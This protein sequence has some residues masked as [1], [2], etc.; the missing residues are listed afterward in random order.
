M[1]SAFGYDITSNLAK[2]SNGG[3]IDEESPKTEVKSQ[4][5]KGSKYSYEI[6][7]ENFLLLEPEL[8]RIFKG[9]IDSENHR[10]FFQGTSKERNQI[11]IQNRCGPLIHLHTDHYHELQD[12]MVSWVKEWSSREKKEVYIH[13]VKYVLDVLFPEAT[14]RNTITGL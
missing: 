11:Q 12:S 9:E 7:K 14:V 1:E 3:I 5:P 2:N 4:F 6:L 13:E 8:Y 10:I